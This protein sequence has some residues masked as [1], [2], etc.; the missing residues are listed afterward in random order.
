[1]FFVVTTTIKIF[2]TENIERAEKK[3]VK[4]VLIQLFLCEICENLSVLRALAVKIS[5]GIVLF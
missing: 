4:P 5:F 2:T 3:G 1:M